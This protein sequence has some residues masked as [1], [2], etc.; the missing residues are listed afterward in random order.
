MPVVSHI[1]YI[2]TSK[3]WGGLEMNQLKNAFWM[4]QRGHKVMVFAQKDSQFQYEAKKLNIPVEL[5]TAPKKVFDFKGAYRLAKLIDN[6]KITHLIV[7]DPKEMSVTGLAKRLSK[8]KFFLAYFMEMQIGIPKRDFVHTIRYKPFDLWS[9]PLPW[10]QKQV[11]ELTSFPIERTKVIPS[12]LELDRFYNSFDKLKAREILELDPDKNY[13]GL[14]GRLDPQKGQLLLLDAFNQIQEKEENY[15]IVFL[16]EPTHG[17]FEDYTTVLDDFIRASSMQGRVHFRPFRSDVETFYAA[18]DIFVMGT[19]SETFGMV[20]IEAMA[21]G[22]KIVGSN[23][24]GTVEILEHGKLGY[25]YES[26]SAEDMA[27][28]IEK[29][30]HDSSFKEEIVKEAAYKYDHQL[31]CK[32]V[33]EALGL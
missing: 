26:D 20:T 30:I 6:L 22:C 19:K 10:L 28:K 15:N 32:Q 23:K 24:G 25:L 1:A 9:C 27:E 14:A 5:I 3:S 7:R 4:M 8:N 16:G 12:G 31:V 2:C 33:E 17:E 18:M 11:K 21:S 29:A 13:I